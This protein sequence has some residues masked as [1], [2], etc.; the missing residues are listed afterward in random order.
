MPR[1]KINLTLEVDQDLVPGAYHD[2][3]SW[4]EF[5]ES[6]LTAGNS[7]NPVVTVHSQDFVNEIAEFWREALR[8]LTAYPGRG[9][10]IVLADMIDTGRFSRQYY[11]RKEEFNTAFMPQIPFRKAFWMIKHEW[12]KTAIELLI[13][14]HLHPERAASTESLIRY[15]AKTI[16]EAQ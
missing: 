6:R 13:E 9:I 1:I 2:P 10:C 14:R 8:R 5:A 4:A 3:A 7:Y 15:L 12:R 16:K 11:Q